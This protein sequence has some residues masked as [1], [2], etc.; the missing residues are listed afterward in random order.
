MSN[1]HVL[2]RCLGHYGYYFG[3]LVAAKKD[4]SEG[5]G[6]CVH[7]V[8]C[9]A[10]TKQL[11]KDF[12]WERVKE[13]TILTRT[14]G[15]ERALEIMHDKYGHGDPWDSLIIRNEEDGM[16]G[17]PAGHFLRTGNADD[18]RLEDKHA[19]EEDPGEGD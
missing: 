16:A 15:Y 11:L 4:R 17:R 13:F 18:L 3:V 2:H 6:D 7:M 12:F 10:T 19:K 9:K 8:T 14:N 1:G 5:C